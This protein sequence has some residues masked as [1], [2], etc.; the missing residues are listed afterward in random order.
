MEKAKI[1]S[2]RRRRAPEAPEPK[3]EQLCPV[4]LDTFAVDILDHF[5]C[6]HK[7]CNTCYPKLP[8]CPLCRTTKDGLTGAE[9]EAR[10]ATELDTH[11]RLEIY[12]RREDHQDDHQDDQNDAEGPFGRSMMVRVVGS[13]PHSLQSQLPDLIASALNGS[14]L[15]GERRSTGRNQVAAVAAAAANGRFQF[16][17]PPPGM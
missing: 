13:I 12:E 9:A 5:P 14:G 3:Q 16:F 1:I 6:A 11:V 15:L 10:R 4:C 17:R 8:A 7:V 2:K